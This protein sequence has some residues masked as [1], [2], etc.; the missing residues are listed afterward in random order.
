LEQPLFTRITRRLVHLIRPALITVAVLC[1]PSFALAD[2]PIFPPGSSVGITPPE[3]MLPAGGFLGFEDQQ[4]GAVITLYDLPAEAFER[5]AEDFTPESM[6]QQGIMDASRTEIALEGTDKAILITG[7]TQ[8]PEFSVQK[9][10][11]IASTEQRAALV[12]GE[13]LEN[14]ERYDEAVMRTAI[15]SLKFRERPSLTERNALLPFRVGDRADFRYIEA[16][17]ELALVLTDGEGD[18]ISNPGQPIVIISALQASTPPPNLRGDFA[19][20]ALMSIEGLSNIRVERS[21]GFRQRNDDWHEIVA[22]A[23]DPD[24][25]PLVVM[26]TIRF[27]REG[28]FRALAT[29]RVED[30]AEMMP[31]FR[32]VIDS[33][34]PR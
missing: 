22:E 2:E 1:I 12:V 25:N 34:E 33:L 15:L 27:S 18:T 5:I 24:G 16:P 9:W 21:E 23:N 19:R 17:V 4:A 7:K 32:R 11:L 3:G 31:R 14:N 28:L 10:I 8:Q 20:G 6:M 26:Q 13:M 29:V 30:R